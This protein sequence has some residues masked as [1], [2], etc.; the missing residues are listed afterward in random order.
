MFVKDRMTVNPM[1]IDDSAPIIEAG[2]IFR[3]NNFARLP[4]MHD[5]KLVGIITQDDLLK[6]SPSQATTLSVWELNYV[7]SKLLIKDAMTKNPVI[8]SP[9]ATLEEVALLMRE[10]EIGALPV[11][12]HDKLVGII[13]ESDIFDAFIDLMGLKRIGTRISI[14]LEDKV[15]A[16]A[17]ITDLLRNEGINIVSLALFHHDNSSKELSSGELVLRLDSSKSEFIVEKLKEKGYK[18]LHVATWN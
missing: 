2:E 18:V 9:N 10:K 6:V 13:T 15:G 1:T 14:D 7:L 16:V 12:E 4:V 3:K 17:Q 5:G 11:V 8:V